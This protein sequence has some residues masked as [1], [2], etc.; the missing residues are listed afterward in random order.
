MPL[1]GKI[2]WYIKGRSNMSV[3]I[4][5]FIVLIVL[6]LANQCLGTAY[7]AWKDK[8]HRD[9]FLKGLG[10]ILRLFFCYGAVTLAAEFA[11]EYIPNSEYLSGILLE[12]I[13]K[14]Y[15]KI[16]RSMRDLLNDSTQAV[17]DSKA[18]AQLEN[19]KT[20]ISEYSKGPERGTGGG[21]P[22]IKNIVDDSPKNPEITQ[23]NDL[24]SHVIKVGLS[25][26]CIGFGILFAVG[27]IANWSNL[28]S[29]G[30]Q[31]LAVIMMLLCCVLLIL[32]GID[33]WKE[34]DRNYLLSMFSSLVALAALGVTIF[35]N[36]K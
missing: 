16:C 7:G 3:S 6:M 23:R 28:W 33:I 13:A 19:E 36:N 29:G 14:Y 34:K 31:N 4:K 11:G 26:L 17:K 24:F 25:T 35:S 20:E 32:L 18:N 22:T 5:L 27:T 21:D 30:M 2:S 8:F 15:S 12:P 10:K 9:Y 1:L